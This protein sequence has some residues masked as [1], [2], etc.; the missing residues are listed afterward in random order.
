MSD[1][2]L[3]RI[4]DRAYSK[5][6]AII[7]AMYSE[8]CQMADVVARL[9]R[10]NRRP[11]LSLIRVFGRSDPA[12][13]ARTE[14]ELYARKNDIRTRSARPP[15]GIVSAYCTRCIYLNRAWG[16]RVCDYLTITGER[17]GCPAGDGCTRRKER[18]HG[19]KETK[20]SAA[21]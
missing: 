8:D 3:L 17:R 6:Y 21:T 20:K 5:C 12:A 18:R 14:I 11:R 15:A 13:I 19:P 16:T 4:Y 9:E 1:A 2:E 10:L 7:R